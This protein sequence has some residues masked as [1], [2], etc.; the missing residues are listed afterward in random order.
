LIVIVVDRHRS[1]WP[2]LIALLCSGVMFVIANHLRSD[3]DD[4]DAY[5]LEVEDARVLTLT[6]SAKRV[7]SSTSG[8]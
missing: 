8:A 7:V 6:L 4:C 5:R 1:T 3:D 2:R